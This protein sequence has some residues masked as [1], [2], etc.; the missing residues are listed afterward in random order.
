MKSLRT[1][2]RRLQWQAQRGSAL[3]IAIVL[4]L[5]ASGLTVFALNIG[6]QEQRAS[7]NDM[8]ARYVQQLADSA[9]A[10]GIE[11]VREQ[12]EGFT[13][14]GAAHWVK[15]GE[16]EM[17]FPCGA[18][19]ADKRERMYY[20]HDAGAADRNGDGVVN[21]LD[22]RMLPVA[23]QVGAV[24]SGFETAYGVGVGICW[25]S[26]DPG[27]TDCAT[28]PT[29]AN[30]AVLASF[31][32]QARI[33]GEE[34]RATVTQIVGVSSSTQGFP[35][36]PPLVASGSLNLT[37]T[38]QVVTH[39]N[40]GGPGVPV[41][42]W[43]RGNLSSAGTPNTCYADEYFRSGPAEFEGGGDFLTCGTKGKSGC[44]CPDS[45]SLTTAKGGTICP[46]ID[47]LAGSYG[48]TGCPAPNLTIDPTDPEQFPCDM[49]EYIF[50]VKSWD[51]INPVDNFCETKRYADPRSFDQYPDQMIERGADVAY[52]D[53]FADWIVV[54]GPFPLRY[55]GDPRVVSCAE[56]GTKTGLIW[57]RQAGCKFPANSDV[58]SP[59]NPVIVVN[60]GEMTIN[61]GTT[62]FGL[63][64]LRETVCSERLLPAIATPCQLTAAQ[65]AAGGT[66]QLTL[67]G[68]SAIYGALVVQ[69]PGPI[70]NGT[71]HVI[72]SPDLLSKLSPA[73]E[74]T[75]YKSV[76]GSWTDRVR[77]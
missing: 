55:Q 26:T 22:Q 32:G 62:V 10:E 45:S 4:L 30:K 67:N 37:G 44:Y 53:R 34:A 75:T 57:I 20:Y 59:A 51:D 56:A 47:V 76:P 35:A 16:N 49:F 15:C 27:A 40:A 61:A 12:G 29:A 3:L 46:G 13:A 2:A 50:N 38:M 1:P 52:L 65:Q 31:V 21:L 43:T 19:P 41:S 66:A 69:G 74:S 17:S 73:G 5:L 23:R 14:F 72:S 60:D 9:I 64:F 71:A 54:G 8:R 77:Y 36:I 6:M 11:Y 63:V 28:S 25:V 39:P 70:V 24:G 68:G 7:G 58:G 33:P 18:L 48:A 42:I